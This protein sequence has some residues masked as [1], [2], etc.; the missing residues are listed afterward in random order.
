MAFSVTVGLKPVGGAGGD[1]IGSCTLAVGCPARPRF[2]M[3]RN[4]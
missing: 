3:P 2:V 1:T 4:T